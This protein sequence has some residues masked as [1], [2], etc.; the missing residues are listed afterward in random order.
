MIRQGG[1]CRRCPSGWTHH[2]N[3]S[4]LVRR[5]ERDRPKDR[6]ALRG[7]SLF[8]SEPRSRSRSVSW[9]SSRVDRGSVLV[10]SQQSRALSSSGMPFSSGVDTRTPWELAGAGSLMGS[11]LYTLDSMERRRCGVGMMVQRQDGGGVC[12]MSSRPKGGTRKGEDVQVSGLSLERARGQK[13]RRPWDCGDGQE[14][15]EGSNMTS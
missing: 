15:G 8:S 5:A 3:I 13:Q 10:Q 14:P 9:P 11:R 7:W 1:G 6:E 12:P 4:P 2:N